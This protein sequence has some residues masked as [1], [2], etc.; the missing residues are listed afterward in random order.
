MVRALG[1]G[2]RESALRP[3][4]DSVRTVEILTEA[5]HQCGIVLTGD[6]GTPGPSRA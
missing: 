1:A 2:E 3:L 5:R 4:A 6:R